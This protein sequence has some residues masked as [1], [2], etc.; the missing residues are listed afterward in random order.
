M[1]DDK[2]GKPPPLMGAT[3]IRPPDRVGM[4]KYTH[5]IYDP[6]NGTFFTRTPK[7][8]A[9]ITIFYCIFYSCLAGFFLAYLTI[10][11]NIQI[12]DKTPTW[13]LDESIIGTN[14]W[15]GVMPSHTHQ[16]EKTVKFHVDKKYNCNKKNNY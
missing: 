13:M 12:N 2:S 16:L 4:E 11:L 10:Y 5:I 9:L 1:A 15:I 3:A 6:K 8:W 14:P 7:S